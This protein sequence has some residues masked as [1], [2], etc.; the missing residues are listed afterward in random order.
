VRK[1]IL[2]VAELIRNAVDADANEVGIILHDDRLG[3]FDA[4]EVSDNGH[5]MPSSEAEQLFQRIGGSWKKGGKRSREKNRL[6]HGQEGHGRF[7]AFGLGRVVDW[8]VVYR[9]SQGLRAFWLSMIKGA[10]RRV[11]IGDDTP[12]PGVL[13]GAS[14]SQCGS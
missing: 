4:I 5:G 1:S 2:A 12:A 13:N 10:M 11:E 9:D 6:L 3:S 8:D 7:R 14:R